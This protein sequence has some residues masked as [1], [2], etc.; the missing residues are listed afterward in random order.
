MSLGE[1]TVPIKVDLQPFKSG[2]EKAR[3]E[4]LKSQTEM[5]K[6]R[7]AKIDAANARMKEK[8]GRAGKES[9]EAYSR[10][11]LR[12]LDSVLGPRFQHVMGVIGKE[13][14]SSFSGKMILAIAAVTAAIGT[15]IAAFKAAG[16]ALRAFVAHERLLG[17]IASVLRV[18]GQH[19]GHTT[20]EI[21]DM[22]AA[23]AR[24]GVV[25]QGKLLEAA[26]V[27]STFRNITGQTF[28][29]ALAMVGDLSRVMGTDA[30]SAAVQL[31]KALNDPKT[32]LASL[33]ESGVSFTTAQKDMIFAMQEAGDVAGMQTE[34]LKIMREQ[35]FEQNTKAADTLADQWDRLKNNGLL[36]IQAIGN[37]LSALTGGPALAKDAA[38]S[39]GDL[40]E[41]IQNLADTISENAETVSTFWEGF[42]VVGGL[43]KPTNLLKTAVSSLGRDLESTAEKTKEVADES[44]RLATALNQI[45]FQTTATANQ[46]K[47]LVDE[48][49]R[50]RKASETKMEQ[51]GERERARLLAEE[52]FNIQEQIDAIRELENARKKAEAS[53]AT[54]SGIAYHESLLGLAEDEIKAAKKMLDLIRARRKEMQKLEARSMSAEQFFEDRI[55]Q[56]IKRINEEKEAAQRAEEEK[57]RAAIKAAEAQ[58]KAQQEQLKLAKKAAEEEKKLEKERLSAVLQEKKDKLTEDKRQATIFAGDIFD[59]M[60]IQKAKD[61]LTKAIKEAIKEGID[62]RQDLIF[63]RLTT[64]DGT[65]RDMIVS[66]LDK[67][68]AAIDSL[69]KVAEDNKIQIERDRRVPPSDTSDQKKMQSAVIDW[70]MNYRPPREGRSRNV[71]GN[72]M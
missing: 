37:L 42:K 63:K 48:Y 46:I 57:A 45:E 8:M 21:R 58:K 12:T 50:L 19:T 3:L 24:A 26:A 9:G 22:T 38:D 55:S 32:G 14:G 16:A 56:R 18:T 27:M 66:Q 35:G 13:G 28:R 40:A 5:A 47:S 15:I 43:T 39:I 23:L 34:I 36:L 7:K 4:L 31:A 2:L 41:N 11:I 1:A 17:R 49:D 10:G 33:R 70:I 29:E 64:E 53:E 60:Q 62:F 51:R 69:R 67:V 54:R 61:S 72:T 6:T 59:S 71:F 30:R 20:R 25:S 65:G 68:N 52:E 44:E